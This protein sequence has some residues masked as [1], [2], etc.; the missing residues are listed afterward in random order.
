MRFTEKI[1]F[2]NGR[3]EVNLPW[4]LDRS[5]LSN[6]YDICVKRLHGLRRRLQQDPELL[7]VYDGILKDQLRG[8]IIEDV[9]ASTDLP[10]GVHYLPHH[11]VVRKDRV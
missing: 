5:K 2:Q 10:V 7:A 1:T 9:A 4:R 6:N 11:L 3:Y 8:G